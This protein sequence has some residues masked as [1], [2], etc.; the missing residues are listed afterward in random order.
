[1]YSLLKVLD[2][3]AR[4]VVV[5]TKKISRIIIYIHQPPLTPLRQVQII[6]IK[7]RRH[8]LY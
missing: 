5:K 4:I 2:L 3:E 1:M 8:Q 6:I 7:L